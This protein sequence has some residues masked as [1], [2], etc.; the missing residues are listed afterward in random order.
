[1]SQ[2]YQPFGSVAFQNSNNVS[3]TG[4]SIT[5][6]SD[7]LVSDGGTGASTLT[8][9]V[10][11]NGTS[12]LVG[13]SLTA[14]AAG[15][16]IANNNGSA[17]NPTFALANDLAAIE[18]LSTNGI[19]TRTTTDTWTTRTVAGTTNRVSLTNGDGVS[20]NPTIDIAATY[21]GQTSITTLGTITTGVWNGTTIAIAN[22]GTNA[23]DAEDARVNLGCIGILSTT[24]GINGKVATTTNLY[25]VPSGKTAVIRGANLRLTTVTSLS[26]TLNAGI[27]IASG[28]QDIFSRVSMTGFNTAGK[29]WA[30]SST[31]SQV[32]GTA[33]QIIK[34][35]IATGFGGTTAT[36]A[37]ELIGY[38][39]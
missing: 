25:T 35:G 38:L 17:A 36:L 26:G 39:I 20:G 6:I 15:I 16:T 2:I 29:T 8:G 37:V 7:L 5:G 21:I 13:R 10:T 11:G 24:T 9:I 31:G 34:L 1:M 32:V 18:G 19:A 3:I 28:E 23:T 12:G 22:G 4:G 27:G 30:F 33:G 14:P